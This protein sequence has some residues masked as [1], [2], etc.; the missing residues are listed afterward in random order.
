MHQQS[1]DG[2]KF[3]GITIAPQQ[4]GGEVE[5]W[6]AAVPVWVGWYEVSKPVNEV[7][8][9]LVSSWGD[10]TVQ[11]K[12]QLWFGVEA[13]VRLYFLNGGEFGY[14]MLL[15]LPKL[16]SSVPADQVAQQAQLLVELLGRPNHWISALHEDQ[17]SLITLPLLREWFE[18]TKPLIPLSADEVAQ[19]Y[20]SAWTA[21]LRAT[22]E[23]ADWF[24]VVDSPFDLKVTQAFAKR[25]LVENPWCSRSEHM[26][27]YGPHL[28]IPG[29]HFAGPS[30]AVCGV[31]AR[32]D[33]EHGIWKAPANEVVV[34]ALGVTYREDQLLTGVTGFEMSLNL[35]RRVPGQAHVVKVW[36]CRTLAFHTH[37][38][39]RYIQVRRTATWVEQQL[40]AIC[41]FAVFEPNT[42]LTWL[43]LR[44]SCEAW[45][46]RLWE[47][48]GLMGVEE[49]QAFLVE[50]GLGETMT[51]AEVNAGV[52]RVK[53]GIAVLQPA[54][55]LEVHMTV[56]HGQ[57]VTSGLQQVTMTFE[58]GV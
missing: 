51:M 46:R 49:S 39:C 28:E 23:R 47:E 25:L 7:V 48:G 41:Q 10:Y 42:R 37:P 6:P 9:R 14:V 56:T 15:P 33:A 4:Q 12:S 50:V 31:M 44:T 1:H 5:A 20:V 17:V 45:L 36:G 19:N 2:H 35:I 26:A 57:S 11:S 8:W 16:G 22:T 27:I 53:V 3:P 21:V 32:V 52:I 54:E 29:Q 58:E 34:G 55:F 38:H 30:G 24:F 18:P 40:R 43:R 13:A